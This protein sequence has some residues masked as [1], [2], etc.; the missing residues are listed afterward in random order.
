M[1]GSSVPHAGGE[2]TIVVA[3]RHPWAFVPAAI[4]ALLLLVLGAILYV[5]GT[6]FDG[7]A[8]F[9]VQ[10][11]D[12][13]VGLLTLAALVAGAAWTIVL[14]LRWRACQVIVT[15]RRVVRIEGVARRDV[16]EIQLDAIADVV[17]NDGALG[18]KLGYGDLLV[19]DASGHALELRDIRRPADLRDAIAGAQETLA[20]ERTAAREAAEAAEAAAAGEPLEVAGV[21]DL[22]AGTAAALGVPVIEQET[23]DEWDA[24][25]EA[26]ADAAGGTLPIAMPAADPALRTA[27]ADAAVRAIETLAALRDAGTITDEDF[28][29]KKR[30]LLDRI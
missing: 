19:R 2:T 11:A 28:E 4:R 1:A 14:A 17:R 27:D 18:G 25:A 10:L 26:S 9:L 29:T 22:L 16:A 7:S 6:S 5:V 3:H 13:L 30:E 12:M 15:T 23:S 24:G 8:G 20:R 21:A